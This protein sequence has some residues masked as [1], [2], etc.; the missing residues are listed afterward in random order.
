MPGEMEE[1]NKGTRKSKRA[2]NV[3]PDSPSSLHRLAGSNKSNRALRNLAT[4]GGMAGRAKYESDPAVQWQLFAAP[5][6]ASAATSSL[7]AP[8]SAHTPD[9]PPPPPATDSVAQSSPGTTFS[10][11][12]C[13]PCTPN[14]NEQASTTS[15]TPTA[16]SATDAASLPTTTPTPT[17]AGTKRPAPSP[18]V[19]HFD[20]SAKLDSL[21]ATR[22]SSFAAKSFTL[23][24]K[25]VGKVVRRVSDRIIAAALKAEIIATMKKMGMTISYDEWKATPKEDRIPVPLTVTLDM[26]DGRSGRQ[27]GHTTRSLAIALQ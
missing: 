7:S 10:T 2:R 25:K 20:P 3:E 1:V 22:S 4:V 16:R 5:S 13:S 17:S 12:I 6:A 11:L 27:D 23:I 18:C 19:V 8:A 14:R 21:D 24:E 15:T 26:W 9:L